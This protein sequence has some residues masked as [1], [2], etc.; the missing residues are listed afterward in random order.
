MTKM[1]RSS[2]LVIVAVSM[3]GLGCSSERKMGHVEGEVT[4]EGKPLAYGTISFEVVGAGFAHGEIQDGKLINVTTLE[5]RDGVPIGH[6]SV[7][8]RAMEELAP[9][10][11]KKQNDTNSVDLMVASKNLV[12]D[13]Y[14]NPTTSGLSAE[15]E[16]GDNFL[17]FELTK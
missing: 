16:P 10:K 2:L 3:M 14:A 7:A 11:A 13:R 5:P 17:K 1:F 4:F 6:A 8:I 15:I 9:A 12:P